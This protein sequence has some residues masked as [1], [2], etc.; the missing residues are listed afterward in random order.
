MPEKSKPAVLTILYLV[1]ADMLVIA[2]AICGRMVFDWPPMHAFRPF[3]F[4]MQFAVVLAI[5]GLLQALYGLVRKRPGHRNAGGIALA[6]AL[7]PVLTA[8]AIVGPDGLKAPMIHDI[9]T[10]TV[11]PPQFGIIASLRTAADNSLEYGGPEIAVQQRAAYPDITSLRTDTPVTR[12]FAAA[13]RAA[14]A[15][16]WELVVVD[17]AIG[18]IEAY[19]SS[20]VFGFIDDVVIRTQADDTGSIIDIRS[21]SRAGLGDLGV[22]ASRIRAFFEMYRHQLTDATSRN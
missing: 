13:E 10:D 18:T 14:R 16:D 1:I 6:L 21:V 12:A 11:N 8:L 4:A 5:A 22:N 7:L 3:F 9:S 2:A 20:R 19:D 17:P 15:L